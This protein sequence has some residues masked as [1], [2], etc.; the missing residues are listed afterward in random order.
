MLPMYL[1]TM[2]TMEEASTEAI[3]DTGA[4]KDFIDQDFIDH[5]KLPIHKLPQ[6][7]PI[8]NVD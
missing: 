8:Y 5:T 6:L 1:K 2:Y 7:I 3:V 4:T